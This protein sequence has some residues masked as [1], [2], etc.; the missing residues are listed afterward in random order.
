MARRFTLFV[1]ISLFFPVKLLAQWHLA[2][3]KDPITGGNIYV[4]K[5]D[6]VK[7]QNEGKRTKA[8][9][10]L[11]FSCNSQ[12]PDYYWSMFL[13]TAPVFS[14][15]EDKKLPMKSIAVL[16]LLQNAGYDKRNMI[17]TTV[18]QWRKKPK[19]LPFASDFTKEIHNSLSSSYDY[20]SIGFLPTWDGEVVTAKVPLKGAVAAINKATYKCNSE[21]LMEINK[22]QD[23]VQKSL[24]R[25]EKRLQEI[26][27][28]LE[29]KE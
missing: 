24:E 18:S 9:M 27:E 16:I 19:E 12:W 4:A 11:I 21:I 29:S 28:R 5:I 20:L 10:S 26:M 15:P 1:I 3:G 8:R 14:V 25:T 7:L 17:L 22:D 13:D 2:H 23:E 6:K